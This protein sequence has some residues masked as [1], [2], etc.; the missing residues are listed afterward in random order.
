MSR[1]RVFRVLS[2][3]FAVQPVVSRIRVF[4]D[5]VLATGF[6]VQPV[7]SRIRVFSDSVQAT[8]FAVQPLSLTCCVQNQTGV[9]RVMATWFALQHRNQSA[10]L[11]PHTARGDQFAVS[12]NY[13]LAVLRGHSILLALYYP[14]NLW[15]WVTDCWIHLYLISETVTGLRVSYCPKARCYLGDSGWVVNSL[16]FAWHRLSPLAAFTSGAYFLH[17]GRR[18]EW[19][20]EFYTANVKG[21]FW[22]T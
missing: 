20:C 15:L 22:G 6:A 2:T 14:A 1:I 19:I 12:G 9:F 13:K 11:W 5:S 8:G 21:I 7:V 17:N 18:W 3:G 16:D 10:K 4:S